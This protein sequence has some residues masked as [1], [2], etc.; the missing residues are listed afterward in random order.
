M[1]PFFSV[2]SISCFHEKL[3]RVPVLKQRWALPYWQYL[4]RKHIFDCCISMA[5]CFGCMMTIKLG[6]DCL[7]ITPTPTIGGR[8]HKYQ[9]CRHKSFVKTNTFVATKHILCHDKIMLVVKTL[10]LLWQKFCR[11][12]KKSLSWQTRLLREA[13]LC[14]DKRRVLSRQTHVCRNKSKLVVTKLLWRQKW[15]LWQLQP[16]KSSCLIPILPPVKLK[17]QHQYTFYVGIWRELTLPAY[18]LE[19]IST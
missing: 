11:E 2:M 15:Y 12:R 8:C 5:L 19:D 4:K 18:P 14:C 3:K 1:R 17:G 9:L 6:V 7:P 10:C 16:M 13:C